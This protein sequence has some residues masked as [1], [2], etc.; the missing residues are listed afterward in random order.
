MVILKDICKDYYQGKMTTKVLK[1]VSLEI[2]EGEYVAVM[3]PSGSG[4]TTLMNIIGCLDSP[5]SGNY[6]LDGEDVASLSENKMAVIRNK[7]IGF[8]FQ[9]F[10]LLPKSNA[11]DNVALPLLYGG[12]KKSKRRALAK[13]ALE[14]VGL[15]DRMT[16]K[17]GQLSGGQ[18]QRV[19]IARA[20]AG[21][22][23]ILLADE[24]TGSL[25]SVSGRSIMELFKQLHEEG[26]TII[27]ITHS[28]NV[29]SWADRTIQLFDGEIADEP[30]A[31]AD[32]LS[33]TL[34]ETVTISGTSD[35]G[36]EQP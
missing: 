20:I 27:M 17:P 31:E 33:D 18:C 12:M 29:A 35:E 15:S 36:G 25:D 1:N 13:Q 7:K 24:P 21:N 9:S 23:K 26:A 4:K 16:Y 3:G 6:Y 34:G 2:K 30:Q 11:I 10:Y 19:A 22:P 8:I 32:N 28:P 14:R 5:T